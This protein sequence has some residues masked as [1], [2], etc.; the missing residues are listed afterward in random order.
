M[1]PCPICNKTALFMA[2]HP[3]ANIYRCAACTHAFSDPRSMAA[4]E[5]YT[6]EYYDHIHRRWFEHPN[7]ALFRSLAALVRPGASV[8]DVGCGRGDFLRYVQAVHPTAKLTG[9][10]YTANSD[11]S[12]RFVQGDVSTAHFSETFDVI[13]SLAVIEHVLDCGGF[14]HRLHELARPG[15]TVAVMTLNESG[16]LYRLARAGRAAGIPL[17]F[18]RLYSRHHLHHFTR[19]SLRQLLTSFGFQID[20][21]FDHNAPLRA[22]DLPVTNVYLDGTLRAGLGALWITGKLSGRS[23]LQTAVCRRK[24][25]G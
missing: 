17:A 25:A 1:L 21:H 9:I 22:M 14:V 16:L 3:E 15:G 5:S 24:N 23:Y 2:H 20:R 12:I 7:L 6:H 19:Q 11:A 8:L 10:D 18:D 4:Q 13:V